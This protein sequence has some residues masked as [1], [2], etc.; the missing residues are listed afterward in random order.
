MDLTSKEY[1]TCDAKINNMK[2]A[3]DSVASWAKDVTKTLAKVK[4]ED[5]MGVLM[6][7]I[8]QIMDAHAKQM[9]E[10]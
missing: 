7:K 3:L 10:I 4:N 5:E 8:G 2:A 9:E 6:V 1:K